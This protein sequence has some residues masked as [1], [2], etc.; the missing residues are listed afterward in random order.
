MD[1]FLSLSYFLPLMVLFH[2]RPVNVNTPAV[3]FFNFDL[4]ALYL[5][6]NSQK[7]LD[8]SQ[9]SFSVPATLQPSL[10]LSELIERKLRRFHFCI[11]VRVQDLTESWTHKFNVE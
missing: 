2:P 6:R 1:L 10:C 3:L 9:Y 5:G 7:F 11:C 4:F 8:L